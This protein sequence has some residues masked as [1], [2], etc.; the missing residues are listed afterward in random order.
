MKSNVFSLLVVVACLVTEWG[1]YRGSAIV[2]YSGIIAA[3]VFVVVL[4]KESTP[5]KNKKDVHEVPFP[6]CGGCGEEWDD[7]ME[8]GVGTDGKEQWECQDCIVKRLG[9]KENV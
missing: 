4:C 9:Q 6:V 7:T 3:L 1:L 2:E 5:K 8:I